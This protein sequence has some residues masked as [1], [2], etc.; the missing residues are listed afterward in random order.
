MV[1][2]ELVRETADFLSS[3]NAR[4][5]AEQ[6][7]MTVLDINRTRLITDGAKEVPEQDT[8]A[9]R[10]MALR[11]KNGEPLQY[12]L[13][14]CEFMSLEFHVGKGVLIPRPDTE[15]LVE[16]VIKNA[17]QSPEIL[18]ICCGSGCIG[19]SLAHFIADARVDM[20]DISEKAVAA[21]E[22]NIR[23]NSVTDRVTVKKT[24]IFTARPK[25]KYDIIVSNP[26]YIETAMIDTLQTE[27]KDYEP[28]EA[29]DGGADGLMFYRRITDI[30]PHMLN[31][32][33]L[34]AFEIGY[35]QGEAVKEIMKNKFADIRV[36]KD[37]AGNDRVVTGTVKE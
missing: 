29:L 26:P 19:I 21:S 8:N 34:L 35:N 24:D 37:L 12:I 2:S 22:I 23:K 11:R 27:V 14:S 20:L 7:V 15:T 31:E 10:E 30:A 33:G 32:N 3:S 4:F 36:V 16:E 18:D 6:L 28:R 5:E 13:G 9:V 25:K 1:I 17:P